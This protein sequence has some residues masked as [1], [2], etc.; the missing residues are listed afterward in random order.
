MK[1]LKKIGFILAVILLLWAIINPFIF[2]F[3]T[4]DQNAINAF[5]AKGMQIGIGDFKYKGNN[6]HYIHLGDTNKTVLLFVHGS[7]GCWD[8]AWDYFM[9]SSWQKN[10]E[11]ISVDRP[12]FGQSDYGKAKNLF[13]QAEIINAFV[14]DKLVHRKVQLIGH[15]YGGPLVLQ[16]CVEQDSL[17]DKCIIMAGSVSP[18]AEENEWQLNLFSKPALKWIVPGSFEQGIEELL[19]LKSDLKTQ[20]Y[21]EGVANIKTPIVAIYGTKD[22]MVPYKPNVKFLTELY[23][24]RQLQLHRMEG[25]NHF[26]PWENYDEVKGII[27]KVE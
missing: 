24:S 16:L 12:G 14:K 27:Q 18:E 13:E 1:R 4:K 5:A 26:I 7:P 21:L 2:A 3:T 22:N 23:D 20:E 9:D 10:Y 11:L 17:Y 6:L 25:A 8:F 19:W 15:S